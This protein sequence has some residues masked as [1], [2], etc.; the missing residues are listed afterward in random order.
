MSASLTEDF[1]WN[2]PGARVVD[3]RVQFVLAI[4]DIR[5]FFWTE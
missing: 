3:A 1:V 2:V 4:H 5:R